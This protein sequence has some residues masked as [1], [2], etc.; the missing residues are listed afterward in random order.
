MKL[1]TKYYNISI[2]VIQIRIVLS[3]NIVDSRY[4]HEDAVK[5]HS[6][7]KQYK[8]TVVTDSGGNQ[9]IATSSVKFAYDKI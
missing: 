3:N 7:P 2:K 9:S 4:Q 8:W 6:L 5:F 1:T